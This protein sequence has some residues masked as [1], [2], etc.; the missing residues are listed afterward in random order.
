MVSPSPPSYVVL[1]GK[2]PPRPIFGAKG[3]ARVVI[4]NFM[5]CQLDKKMNEFIRMRI[6]VTP[7]YAG[8]YESQ[9]RQAPG[10]QN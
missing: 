1:Y 10:H 9:P 6:L 3:R 4:A 7:A 2:G 8:L 5:T